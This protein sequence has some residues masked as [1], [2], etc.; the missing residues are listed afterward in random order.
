[1]PDRSLDLRFGTTEAD[2]KKGL[3]PRSPAN[4]CQLPARNEFLSAIMRPREQTFLSPR[5][6]CFGKCQGMQSE[7][8]PSRGVKRSKKF[9]RDEGRQLEIRDESDNFMP[10]AP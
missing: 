1:M 6:F 5:S 8:A 2:T 10:P 3:S 4:C 7:T 9:T